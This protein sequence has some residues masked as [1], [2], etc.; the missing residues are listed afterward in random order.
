MPD[1]G[2]RIPGGRS[3]HSVDDRVADPPE[4]PTG[5]LGEEVHFSTTIARG[6]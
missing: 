6:E 1:Q 3:A 4:K 5:E 2:K